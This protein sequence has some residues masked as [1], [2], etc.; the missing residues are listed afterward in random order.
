MNCSRLFCLFLLAFIC[1][2]CASK[3]GIIAGEVEESFRTRWVAKRM[4]ELQAS[5]VATDA[6]EAR[7][8]A[9]EEF[10]KQYPYTS[11]ANKPDPVSG[12]VP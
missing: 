10:S 4:G 11:V 7:R 1:A 6:R 2:G 3:N 12:V 5:G 8:V 9:V